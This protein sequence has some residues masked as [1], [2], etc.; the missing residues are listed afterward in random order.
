MAYFTT[1]AQVPSASFWIVAIRFSALCVCLYVTPSSTRQVTPHC[2][3]R[4]AAQCIA[5]GIVFV[6]IRAFIGQSHARHGVR[7]A[8]RGTLRGRRRSSQ[9]HRPNVLREDERCFTRREECW[10]GLETC[11][12]QDQETLH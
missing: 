8:T 2:K 12:D 10:R 6:G 7:D 9:A 11:L 5:V 1:S 3:A 4:S